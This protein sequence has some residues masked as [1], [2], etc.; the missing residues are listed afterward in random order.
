MR[1]EYRIIDGKIKNNKTNCESRIKFSITNY[2]NGIYYFEVY[3]LNES[4][5][6][7][8]F[9]DERCMVDDHE[10]TGK[11][12]KNEQ[13]TVTNLS[14]ASLKS[15]QNSKIAYECNG[16][17]ELISED[18]SMYNNEVEN[19]I[20][21]NIEY[22]EL[23]G[24]NL[25]LA[26]H[27]QKKLYRS[28]EKVTDFFDFE[29]D[30]YT[31]QLVCNNIDQVVNNFN[32]VFYKNAINDNIILEFTFKENN[33]LALKSYYKIKR[34]LLSI[35]TLANNGN[36]KVRSELF[37][38]Y[39]SKNQNGFVDSS[40]KRIYSFRE[41]KKPINNRYL[42][43]NKKV[44]G[45]NN[46]VKTLLINS[47]DSFIEENIKFDLTNAILNIINAESVE[48]EER[49]YILITVLEKLASRLSNLENNYEKKVLLNEEIFSDLKKD[50]IKTTSKYK[51][52][53]ST[54]NDYNTFQSKI[55]V[56]NRI[57]KNETKE[58][59]SELFKY[60]NVELTDQLRSLISTER[61]SAVH[62][63]KFGDSYKEMYI[64]YFVL[65]HA[66][67]DIILNIIK[68]NGK[69]YRQIYF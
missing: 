47:F 45:S 31:S 46:T 24:L 25:F 22:I 64:N 52:N 29:F 69:R 37:G 68:Y 61:N 39:T 59:L 8:Y 1:T 44:S 41:K 35:L 57:N 9:Q 26:D 18:D 27:T 30:H 20:E 7:Q 56:L 42:S 60:A 15:S 34:D 32:L 14:V 50:L 33:N 5:K 62:E 36:I 53:F 48:I 21:Q 58:K 65:D 54:K 12:D 55:G 11:T 28:G 40:M 38:Q 13:I 16:Y 51:N 63:G 23:E 67:R 4:F 43:I 66:I 17:I 2:I 49:Y 3:L 6:E 19:K 10:L